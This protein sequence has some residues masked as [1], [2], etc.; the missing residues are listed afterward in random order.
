MNDINLFKTFSKSSVRPKTKAKRQSNAGTMR[1]RDQ[2]EK[3]YVSER[4]IREK[5]AKRQQGKISHQAKNKVKGQK[6]GEGFMGPEE[7]KS[8]ISTNDPNDPMTKEKLKTL[9]GSGAMNFDP[10]HR[11]VLAKILKNQ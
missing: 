2:S 10:K 8:D 3:P 1:V 7:V 4:E 9:L 5:I 6:L 11:E